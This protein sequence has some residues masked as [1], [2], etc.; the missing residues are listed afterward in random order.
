MKN[1]SHELPCPNQL[2]NIKKS[3]NYDIEECNPNKPDTLWNPYGTGLLHEDYPFP[4][5]YVADTDEIQKILDCFEKFNNYDYENHNKR[6]LCSIQVNSFM[7]AAVNSEVCI[8]RTN[9]VNNLKPIKFCDPLEGKNIYAT[10]YPR[11][12]IIQQKNLQRHIDKSEKFILITCRLDTTSMFD[13]VGLGA[14]DSLISYTTLMNVAHVLSKILPDTPD[15]AND[16]DKINV[17]YVIFNGESYDY[18]GSQRFVYDLK[19][20]SFPFK[21]T[22]TN[23]ITFDNIKFIIDLGILDDL[24]N[25]K[26]FYLQDQQSLINEFLVRLRNSNKLLNLNVTFEHDLKK[27]L[28]PTSAQSFLRENSTLPCVILSSEPKNQYYHSIYDDSVNIKFYYRNISNKIDFSKLQNRSDEAYNFN[29][30]SIQMKIRDLSTI[31]AYSI[32]GMIKDEEYNGALIANPVLVDELLYCFL[33]SA[34]CPLFRAASH[35]NSLP[36]LPVPPMR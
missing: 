23:P 4:I 36:G 15:I 12:N 27:R 8:R 2:S 9:F 14:M 31:I 18:I 24:N 16:D 29:S 19:H 7:S 1:F 17:L 34:D 28:P 20:L 22:Q 30:D 6:S 32:Y 5:Y 11:K 35:P 3:N 26:L 21:S 25:I 33:Q 13:G 10:L